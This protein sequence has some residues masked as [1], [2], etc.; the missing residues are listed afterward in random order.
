MDTPGFPQESPLYINENLQ[1]EGTII[2]SSHEQG[3]I[4]VDGKIHKRG[5][6]T[7]HGKAS[8]Y[9]QHK[10]AFNKPKITVTPVGASAR[11]PQGGNV[12]C[13]K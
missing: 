3:S 12:T 10:A 13:K 1:N 8:L 5:N 11:F 6:V 9:D 4:Y 2:V 7:C